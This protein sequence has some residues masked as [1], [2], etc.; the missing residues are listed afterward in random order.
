MA[1]KGEKISK[2]TTEKMLSS[3]MKRLKEKYK[4]EII[5]PFLDVNVDVSNCGRRNKNFITLREFKK[6]IESGKTIKEIN[7]ISSR[8]LIQF[9]SNF[10]QGKILLSKENFI[11]EYNKGLSLDEISSKH[12]IPREDVTY[13]RQ[14]YGEKKKGAKFIE[15]KKTETPLTSRQKDIIYGSMMGDACKMSPSSIKF[16]HSNHQKD[17]LIWKFNELENISSERSLQNIKSIDKRSEKNIES[18]QFY[19]HANTDVEECVS[20]FYEKGNKEVS[21][22]ILSHLSPLSIA[23]WFQDDGEVDWHHRTVIHGA[24][25][26]PT[27]ILCTDSYSKESCNKIIKWFEKEF[28]IIATMKDKILSDRIGYRIAISIESC[29]KF[30]DLIKP[31]ILPMFEYKINYDE[32]IN[33]REKK[34]KMNIGGEVLRCPLGADFSIL[35][36]NEQDKKIED[37]VLF[38]QQR[39]ISF[40]IEKENGWREH[41]FSVMNTNPKNLIRD[42]Y[43]AFSNLGNRFL[44]SHFDNFWEAKAKGGMSPKEIFENKDYL[45][46]IIRKIIVNGYFPSKEKILKALQRY[47]GNKQVSGFMPCV[48][49]SIYYKYCNKDSRVLDF[50]AGYGGRMFGAIACNKVQAYTCIEVN[51]KT[52]SNLHDLYRTLRLH[53]ETEKEINIF[54]QDSILAMKL[55][56]DKSFDFCFTSPPYFDAEIY[57]NDKSQS[58]KKYSNYNEWF[59]NYLI[60]CVKE[61]KRVSKK[62]A[63]NIANTGGYLIADHLEN[64]LKKENINYEIDKI[65]MPQYNGD[66]RYEPIFIFS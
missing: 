2:E 45:S 32:Y 37:I 29:Q 48:A 10:A 11:K 39:G 12:N 58:C 8:H 27:F 25:N 28:G 26:S 38:Y 22:E 64:Y 7:K 24:N 19:T 65:R 59:N 61:A 14:L 33:C 40:L 51:F 62:T 66:F 60:G 31:F 17:Y 4:W 3:R 23:V 46:D 9:Y 57:S 44:M 34:E 1:L 15:R 13:L 56:A 42:D 53:T 16:K 47:R 30:I 50:C 20:L 55:F 49:K 36:I 6:L 5:E 41:M 52:Y 18:Y 54:N 63:I 43:F 35:P 21:E